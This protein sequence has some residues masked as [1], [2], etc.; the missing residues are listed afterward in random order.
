MEAADSIC[1]LVMDLED[2]FNK[3]WY[4]FEFIIKFLKDVKVLESIIKYADSK[5]SDVNKMVTFRRELISYLVNLA[6]SNF[7]KNYESIMKGEYEKELIDED[8]FKVAKTLQIFTNQHIFTKKEVR[9]LE[10]TGDSVISGLLDYYIKFLFHSNKQ[11]KERAIG[12]ISRSIIKA[13]NLENGFPPD[14]H[15]DDLPSYYKLR[16]IVDFI[17][18]MTDQYA[19]NHY[20]KLSGQKIT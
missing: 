12:L 19:L 9:F 8:E 16:I 15:F 6:S 4:D 13:A 3:D 1:Y 7:I 20:Q 5:P 18:G 11:Y 10:L 17:S 2:G 14:S